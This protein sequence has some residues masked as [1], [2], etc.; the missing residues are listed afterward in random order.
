[1][2][3]ENGLIILPRL[4]WS[5]PFYIVE[6]YVAGMVTGRR[7]LGTNHSFNSGAIIHDEKIVDVL[8][9]GTVRK[10]ISAP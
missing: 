4:P 6:K 9:I 5:S 2:G 10:I 1:M 3:F 7:R 8:Y